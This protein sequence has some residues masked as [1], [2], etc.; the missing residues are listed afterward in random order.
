[1][2]PQLSPAVWHSSA[3]PSIYF[4]GADLAGV[5]MALSLLT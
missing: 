3:T 5:N 2:Q 4:G 1:M